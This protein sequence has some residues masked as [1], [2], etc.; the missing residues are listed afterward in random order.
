MEW[1]KPSTFEGYLLAACNTV[2]GSMPPWVWDKKWAQP[3]LRPGHHAV[4][5]IRPKFLTQILMMYILL[6]TTWVYFINDVKLTQSWGLIR[7]NLDPLLKLD[8]SIGC[9][10]FCETMLY[11]QNRILKVVPLPWSTALY[12]TAYVVFI[13]IK[14]SSQ[15]RSEIS[16]HKKIIDSSHGGKILCQKWHKIFPLYVGCTKFL[17]HKHAGRENLCGL[18]T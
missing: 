17:L 4:T 3:H 18:H 7:G 14:V 13:K 2:N 15:I 16:L 10:L 11:Q 5:C 9:A 12:I 6:K 8:Q 1:S